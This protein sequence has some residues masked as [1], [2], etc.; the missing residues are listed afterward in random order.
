MADKPL[1]LI[2]EDNPANLRL[3][4]AALSKRDFEVISATNAEEALHLLITNMP[5]LILMDIQ[6]PGVDGLQ[7]TSYL[8]DN[9]TT[10]HITI[11]ALTAYASKLD[12]ER[13]MAAGCDGFIAKPYD[14]LELAALL[15][16]YLAK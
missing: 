6:L 2:V 4:Q 15:R 16:G 13:A 5:E 9:P 3:A 11:V 14:I 8:K 10:K 12:E 1:V 7:L